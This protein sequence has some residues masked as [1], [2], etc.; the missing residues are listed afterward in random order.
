MRIASLRDIPA[1]DASCLAV[2]SNSV[3]SLTAT[4]LLIGL[5]I[6]VLFVLGFLHICYALL[7]NNT[8]LLTVCQTIP[9]A[10]YIACLQILTQYVVIFMFIFFFLFYKL[11]FNVIPKV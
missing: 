6:I 11:L 1:S 7:Y 5:L 9:H 4:V 10:L 3:D 2:L 8:M